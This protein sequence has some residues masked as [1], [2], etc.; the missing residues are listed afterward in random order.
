MHARWISFIQRFTFSIKHKSK[1]LNRVA[2]TL[3]RKA[4]CLINIRADVFGFDYFNELY[5]QD[6]DFAEIWESCHSG[7]GKSG[8]HLHDCFLFRGNQLCIPRTSFREKL[9]IE[10]HSSGLSGHFRRDKTL[11][12]VREKYY[13][14]QLKKDV[15]NFVKRCPLGQSQNT[16]L[17]TPLPIPE[18]PWTDISMDFVLGLPRTQRGADFIMVVVDRFSKMSHFIACKKTNDAV[19]VAHLFFKEIVRLHGVPDIINSDRNS[20]FLSHFW[21]TLWRRFNTMINFSSTCHTQTDGQTEV[22]NRTLG[23]LLRCLSSDRPK[24]WDFASPQAEFAYNSAYH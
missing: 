5:H 6:R 4:A 13:W 7:H 15:E 2:D 1:I 22:A 3:S 19:Q 11:F 8:F 18:H 14:P 21:T 10:L 12:M 23:N 17:Y 20:K 16:G 9:I 24:Q